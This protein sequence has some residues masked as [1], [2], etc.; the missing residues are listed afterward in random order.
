MI[1]QKIQS[2]LT[3]KKATPTVKDNAKAVIE[4]NDRLKQLEDRIDE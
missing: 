1:F 2:A 3:S 4:L